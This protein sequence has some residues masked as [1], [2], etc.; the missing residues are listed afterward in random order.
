MTDSK[1]GVDLRDLEVIS[2]N[3]ESYRAAAEN[4]DFSKIIDLL[5]DSEVKIEKYVRELI[6]SKLDGSFK[7]KRGARANSTETKDKI[8]LGYRCYLW[9]TIIEEWPTNAAKERVAEVMGV[10]KTSVNSWFRELN[11]AWGRMD[12]NILPS[13]FEAV[14]DEPDLDLSRFKPEP[15]GS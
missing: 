1:G 12:R 15:L 6:A 13:F 7:A 8:L 9:L 11:N 3:W 10:S 2:R 14:R 5:R 4:N